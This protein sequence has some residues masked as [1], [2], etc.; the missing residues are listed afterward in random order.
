VRANLQLPRELCNSWT[1][2]QPGS[3]AIVREIREN[4][5]WLQDDLRELGTAAGLC[6]L[7]ERD[8]LPDGGRIM[9]GNLVKETLR[10]LGIKSGDRDAVILQ[11]AVVVQQLKRR[12]DQLERGDPNSLGSRFRDFVA[13]VGP[14][15]RPRQ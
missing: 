2:G 7:R 8:R 4:A 3:D 15:V 9:S 13:K 6:R 11:L 14:P 10:E 12:V 5:F 1:I